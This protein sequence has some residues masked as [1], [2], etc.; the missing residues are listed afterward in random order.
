MVNPFTDYYSMLWKCKASYINPLFANKTIIHGH[1][2]ISISMC[3]ERV[4]SKH[5]VI[6]IDTGC[7]YKDKEGKGRLTAYDCN[8]QRIL[9]V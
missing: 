9:F 7:V 6:N 4:L 3:E 5:H 1:N 8:N 2:S